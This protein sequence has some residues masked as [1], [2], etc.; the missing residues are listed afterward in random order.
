MSVQEEIR[1]INNELEQ[2]RHDLNDTLTRI[3]RKVERTEEE[4]SPNHIVKRRPLLAS[5]C[6]AVMGFAIGSRAERSLA[7]GLL[8]GASLGYV[9]ASASRETHGK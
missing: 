9:L 5:C 7:T 2:A 6:A 3:N 4:F 1:K 8:I